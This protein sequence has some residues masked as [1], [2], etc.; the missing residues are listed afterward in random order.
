MNIIQL[1]L[2]PN[3]HYISHWNGCVI[4]LNGFVTG[5]HK[6]YDKNGTNDGESQPLYIETSISAFIPNRKKSLQGEIDE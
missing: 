2:P 4:R 3:I 6:Q 1:I 5:K